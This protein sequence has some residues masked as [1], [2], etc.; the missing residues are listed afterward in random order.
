M[1][2]WNRSRVF[3]S[4]ATATRPRSRPGARD[5]ITRQV[6]RLCGAGV[7]D[8]AALAALEQDVAN[9]VEDAFRFA[10]EGAPADP[11][12]VFDLMFFEQKP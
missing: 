11:T 6:E 10:Q 12:L 7:C 9:T 3:S 4:P 5:P 1:G 2:T 8:D